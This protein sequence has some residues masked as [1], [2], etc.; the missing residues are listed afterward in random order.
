MSDAGGERDAVEAWMR[1]SAEFTQNMARVSETSAEIWQKVFAAQ[2]AN[3]DKPATPDPLNTLPTFTRFAQVLADHPQEL[4]AATMAWWQ[5]QA[6]LWQSAWSRWMGEPSEP[7]VEP[8]PGDKRFKHDQWS[9]NVLFD[10]LKQSYLLTSSYMQG[11]AHSIGDLDPHERKKVEFY[12][13]SFVE[14]M[15]PSNFFALNPEVLEA[16]ASQK[17]DNLVR[18]LK[19]MLADLE[20]GKGNLLIRQTD[21]D[22][23][24][25]GRDMAVTPGAVIWQN[26]VLQL[27]QYAPTT[28]QV[29]AR[30]L[31]FI[32]PWINK[33]Y[34]LDLNEKK[35]LMKWLVGQGFTVFMISW[36]N[37][38]ERQAGETWE[39]YMQAV[40]DAMDVAMK[41]TGQ[42]KIN[43]ASYCIGGT[44]VGSFLARAAKRKDTRVASATLFTAQLDF[45]DAGELQVFVDD[46]TI[47][48]V[49]DE[50]QK[51]YLPAEKMASAFNM[52]RSA[53]LI[54]GYCVN[55]YMLGKDPF[56][57]D[58]L[59]WNADS[60]AMPAKVHR[61]YL[62]SFYRDNS[63]VDGTLK[64]DGE[65]LSLADIRGPV[66]HVA[67]REDHIAPAPSVYRGARMM[68][69]AEVRFILAGS[70]HIAGVV[71]PPA[72]QKYQYWVN[73]D[74]SAPTLA[75][76][77]EQA[78]EH[79]GSWWVDW[80]AWLI[81]H[82]GRKVKAREPGAKHGVLEP[83]PGE[84]VKVRFDRR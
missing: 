43:L 14:A 64:V 21:M 44:M 56:P 6:E 36:V 73:D 15:S 35:S 39:S 33:Y 45:A 62:E 9:E 70:G 10:Y 8:K 83:A 2:A 3:A 57:F 19:M 63:F 51:G 42:K 38:D 46:K 20:R 34:V 26:N 53:D 47:A 77:M 58:L 69:N 24:E 59:Y 22:A 81:G 40:S 78:E 23:F 76:W 52:L 66:Y 79:P 31:L 13:R 27:I 4:A 12:T 54:W 55:N 74:L 80:E 50:M 18:G 49:D 41:E 60:T 11:T 32:P 17:G 16:T 61:F 75:E 1:E 5:A 29:H 7:V 84:F 30:P 68:E 37:P 71:N 65:T 28:E 67:T 72:A 48:V 25:V 82:S